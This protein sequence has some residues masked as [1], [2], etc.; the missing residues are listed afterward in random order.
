[1]GGRRGCSSDRIDN[2][3]P[4]TPE[5][6]QFIPAIENIFYSS[7]DNADEK[8]LRTYY[9]YYTLWDLAFKK[10][11]NKESIQQDFLRLMERWKTG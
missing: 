8:A 11:L 1:M 3:G 2:D 4:Y 6:C 10:L 7:I 5:N 9:R